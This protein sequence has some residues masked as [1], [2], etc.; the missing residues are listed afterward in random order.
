MW[1]KLNEVERSGE[2]RVRVAFELLL[3]LSLVYSGFVCELRQV[4]R[5]RH[6]QV[7]K[8]VGV[9]QGHAPRIKKYGS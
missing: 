1:G 7:T 2:I 4:V 3:S 9:A 5:D 8:A 6:V